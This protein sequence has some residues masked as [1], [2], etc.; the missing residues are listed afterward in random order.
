MNQSSLDP[1]ATLLAAHLD[2][3]QDVSW[4]HIM[5]ALVETGQ[6]VSLMHLD[7]RLQM[8]QE[9]LT[10]YLARI[11]GAELDEQGHIVGWGITLLPTQHLFRLKECPLF[12]WCAFDTVL[13]PPL[14]QVEASVQ[15]RC[16]ATNQP[17][18]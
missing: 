14:L 4:R 5:Q 9:K 8:S 18:T 12:T 16:S 2:C 15:S 17:I 11:P 6:P 1:L 3:T 10:A 7:T 13:F